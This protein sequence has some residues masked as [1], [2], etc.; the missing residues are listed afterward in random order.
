MH[1]CIT[2]SHCMLQPVVDDWRELDHEP[3]GTCCRPDTINVIAGM[4]AL[5]QLAL[6]PTVPYE[7]PPN[8]RDARNTACCVIS[9]VIH[10]AHLLPRSI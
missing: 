3:C 9:E 5:E 10:V 1:W 7:R 4:P 8:V 2:G 6:A